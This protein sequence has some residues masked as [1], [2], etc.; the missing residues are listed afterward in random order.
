MTACCSPR[1]KE[2]ILRLCFD[3]TLAAATLLVMIFIPTA[4]SSNPILPQLTMSPRSHPY[5]GQISTMRFLSFLPD[6]K[7]PPCITSHR[8]ADCC[9]AHSTTPSPVGSLLNK[10]D[11]LSKP[12]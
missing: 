1:I 4:V 12:H 8:Q 6:T 10:I 11:G 3:G 5:P 7:F 2:Y 9:S